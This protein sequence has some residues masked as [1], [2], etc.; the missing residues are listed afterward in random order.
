MYHDVMGALL[1]V[2]LY[3]AHPF[4][5]KQETVTSKKDTQSVLPS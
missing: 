2:R 1:D 4:C 3:K 5:N